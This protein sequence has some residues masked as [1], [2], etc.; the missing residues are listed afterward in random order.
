MPIVET[1]GATGLVTA[2]LTVAEF[3]PPPLHADKADDNVNKNK[4]ETA[5]EL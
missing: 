1:V 3:N 4:V 2:A 5:S